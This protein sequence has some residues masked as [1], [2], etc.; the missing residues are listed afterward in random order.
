[1]REL[2]RVMLDESLALVALAAAKDPRRHHGYAVPWLRQLLEEQT[3]LT[4]E[5]TALAGSALA[6]L[7]GRRPSRRTR[8]PWPNVRLGVVTNEVVQ[9]CCWRLV[10]EAAVSSS[11]VVAFEVGVEGGRS[12]G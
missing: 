4:L 12:F 5:Q 6:A 8:W 9:P 7:G 11:V 2:G 1:M 10:A 3:G